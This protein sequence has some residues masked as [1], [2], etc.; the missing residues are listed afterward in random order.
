MIFRN[1]KKQ[2][3]VVYESL[4]RL[5]KEKDGSKAEHEEWMH[6]KAVA[7][8]EAASLKLA[9]K[10]KENKVEW[11]KIVSAHKQSR[12]EELKMKRDAERQSSMQLH[13]ENKEADRLFMEDSWRK[14]QSARAE[15]LRDDTINFSQAADRRAVLQR[16][17]RE[18]LSPALQNLETLRMKFQKR[19]LYEHPKVTEDK[20]RTCREVYKHKSTFVLPPISKAYPKCSLRPKGV[21]YSFRDSDDSKGSILPF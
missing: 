13:M 21:D 4:G 2:Q 12:S 14:S 11:I 15:R 19:V 5:K 6:V 10:E 20:I 3:Q 17:R 7:A 8:T 16:E 9:M 1:R 18:K